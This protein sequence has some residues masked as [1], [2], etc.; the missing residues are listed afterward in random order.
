MVSLPILCPISM[1]L[2]DLKRNKNF[3]I[4]RRKIMDNERKHNFYDKW[5]KTHYENLTEDEL[6][7][8]WKDY[9]KARYL[10]HEQYMNREILFSDLEGLETPLDSYLVDQETNVEQEVLSK[11]TIEDMLSVLTKRER[12]VMILVALTGYKVRE[13]AEMMGVTERHAQRL[14]KNARKKLRKYLAEEGNENY[15][16][17]YEY[18][19][20][21]I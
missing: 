16:Q 3:Q 10:E 19:F 12:E 14:K 17:A 6:K 18:L 4:D 20:K 2:V 8:L 5:S 15:R 13:A 9:R 11:L 21:K 1:S 7:A